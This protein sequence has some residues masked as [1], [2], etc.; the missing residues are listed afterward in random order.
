MRPMPDQRLEEFRRPD[1]EREIHGG[2]GLGTGSGCF[3]VR[4][5]SSVLRVIAADAASWL[6]EKMPGEPWE[7]V[8]VSLDHRCPTWEEMCLVKDLFW[9]PEETVMQ[10]HPPQS[11]WINNYAYCL[12][13]WRP[14]G[15]TIPLP[16]DI[17]VGIQAAGLLTPTNESEVRQILK[18][19]ADYVETWKQ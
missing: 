7:H 8:S 10:L 9:L 16:P 1:I 5:E 19:A 12:H 15:A 2:T 4:H 17:C 3:V 14:C 13:L 6:E 18:D 11:R